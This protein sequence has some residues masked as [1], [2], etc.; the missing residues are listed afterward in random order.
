MFPH[1]LVGQQREHPLRTGKTQLGVVPMPD[2]RSRRSRRRC[3]VG[4][5]VAYRGRRAYI[6]AT[7]SPKFTSNPGNTTEGTGVSNA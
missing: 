3:E 5:D 2:R 1:R 7:I 4:P 6:P